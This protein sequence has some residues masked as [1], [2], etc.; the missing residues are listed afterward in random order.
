MLVN[1]FIVDDYEMACLH[2]NN[3][4]ITVCPQETVTISA[5]QCDQTKDEGGKKTYSSKICEKV[6]FLFL[7]AQLLY[8]C[9]R[10][11]DLFSSNV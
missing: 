8:L 5:V 4:S 7:L 6:A 10:Y 11:Y 2:C 9:K 1:S 3:R